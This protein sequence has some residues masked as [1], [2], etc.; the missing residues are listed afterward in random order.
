MALDEQFEPV[1]DSTFSRGKA[2]LFTSGSEG[3]RFMNTSVEGIP[4]YSFSFTTSRYEHFMGHISSF[5]GSAARLFTAVEMSMILG[6]LAL[7]I[8]RF[9]INNGVSD[10]AD[11]M[12]GEIF[13]QILEII[14]LPMPVLRNIDFDVSLPHSH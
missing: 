5:I 3:A 7:A 12:R 10:Q 14:G 1:Y 13:E 6:P 4:L 11:L 2:G 8:S 9:P